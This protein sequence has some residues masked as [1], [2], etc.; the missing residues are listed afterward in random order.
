MRIQRI[1]N[2]FGSKYLRMWQINFQI[3]MLGTLIYLLRGIN[4]IGVYHTHFCF[5]IHTQTQTQSG[6]SMNIQYFHR[7][8]CM[9]NFPNAFIFCHR[10]WNNTK[11]L[12]RNARV[13]PFFEPGG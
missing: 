8:E 1:K 5:Q 2:Q 9:L 7:T 10:L 12:Q 11:Q 3:L 4:A 6:D 13:N